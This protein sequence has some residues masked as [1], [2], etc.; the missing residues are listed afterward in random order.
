MKDKLRWGIVGTGRIA[1]EF[2]AG[3]AHSRHGELVAVAS[4]NPVT[5]VAPEFGRVCLHTGYAELL[6]DKS[7]EAVYIATPHPMHAEWAIRAAEAGKHVLCE[8]PIGM[9]A[10]E[11]D[12]IIDAAR[13]HDVFL[14]EAFMYRAH[15]QTEALTE[16]VR[17]G[18]IGTIRLI[19]AS[20]GFAK[21]FDPAGRQYDPGLGG[22][23]ILDVGCYPVS[24][25][26]LIAGAV[27]GKPFAD[28]IA[29]LGA[30][31]VGATGVDEWAAATLTFPDGLIAQV[32]TGVALAQ[33]NVVRLFG[34]AGRI[35]VFSPWWCSGKQGGQSVISVTRAGDAPREVVTKTTDWLYAI[36][37]DTVARHLAARQSPA[38]SWDDTLGNMRALDALADAWPKRRQR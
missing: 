4:R 20:F 17:S 13:R 27:A 31:H 32:A 29:V 23:G 2:A 30:G 9:N 15:P 37:A 11:A 28:P 18:A 19:E 36:E 34:T 24:M 38:M 16:L 26:R 1:R 8:K 14:M 21:A 10:A 6:A 25:V 22:G 3:I 5:E 35:E 12:A 7:V 33:A